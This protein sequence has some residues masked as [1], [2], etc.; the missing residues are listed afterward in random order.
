MASTLQ[1]A[2]P[3]IG[4]RFPAWLE[5]G[6]T[7]DGCGLQ[8]LSIHPAVPEEGDPGELGGTRR[9]GYSHQASRSEM[10]WDDPEGTVP[11]IA[12]AALCPVT[13]CP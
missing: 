1:L 2:L 13:L 5:G 7:H 8:L 4:Q 11:G 10:E 3:C 9:S 12:G 6:H